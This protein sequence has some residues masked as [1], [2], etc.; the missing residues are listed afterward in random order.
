MTNSPSTAAALKQWLTEEIAESCALEVSEVDPSRPIREYGL[1]SRDALRLVGD[2]EDMLDR[3]L[4]TALIWQH[5][6]IDALVEVLLGEPGETEAA[7]VVVAGATS[8]NGPGTAEPIAV[9]GIGCRLPGGIN[10][11]E[12]FWRLLVEGNHA[13]TR[14][15]D[16][17]WEQ[18]GHDSPEQAE[19][20]SNTTR[21]GGFL[22]QIDLFDA[23]FF[24]IAP[25]EAAAMDPQQRLLLEVAWEA[26]E[27]AGVSAD[28]LRGSQTGVFVG[29]SGNEYSHLTLGDV[30]HIDAWSGTGAAL[31]I[32]ANRLSYVFDL[33]GPSIAVD[34]ACSSS[35]VAVHQAIQSLRAGESEVALAGGANLLLGAGVT[36]TFDQM[37]I[38][39]PDGLCKAFDASADGIARAEGAG[40]VVLKPLS[41]AV[42]D[43]DRVLAVLRGSAVNSD[44]RSNGLTAPN[45]EAQ[46]ALLRTAY[47]SAGVDPAEVDYVEAHGTGTLLGDPIEASALGAVL[48]KG[49][50]NS[51]P[52]LLGSVK[53][54]LGHLEA[55]AGVIG[56]IKTVLALANRRIPA[57]LHFTE[58]NPHIPFDELRITVAAEQQPWPNR[59]RPGRAGVSGFG[60]G[61]TN[62]HVIVEQAPVV[63]Q[64]PTPLA[65]PGQFLLG[66]TSVA[67]LRRTA[68]QLADWLA[69]PGEHVE[70]SDVEHTLARRGSGRS[71]A[72]ITAGTRAELLTGLDALA[73]GTAAPGVALGKRDQI[74]PGPVWVFSGHG[75]QWAGMGKRL[76]TE[77]PVFA[78]AI[79]EIDDALSAVSGPA[80]RKALESGRDL[81]LFDE[82]QPVLFGLQVA[83]ARLWQH[84]GVQPAAVIG[85]SIGEVAAAV[86]AGA[87]S[88]QHGALIAVRRSAR[89]ATTGG[90]GAMAVLELPAT[91]VTRLLAEHP[92]IGADIDVAVYNSPS[93]TVVAGP[94]DKVPAL[95][96]LVEQRGLLARLIKIDVASHSRV[97]DQVTDGLRSD[98]RA[99][100]ALEPSVRI[101][102]TAVDDPRAEVT[103]D[104]AY[105]VGNIRKPVRFTDAVAAAVADG[106]TTFVEISPHPVLFH[107]ISETAGKATVLGTLRRSDSETWHFHANLGSLLAVR[108]MPPA[109]DGRLL[110]VPTTPWTRTVH[111]AKPIIRAVPAGTHPLLGV[112][113][114]LPGE[115]THLWRA[116]LGT[117]AQP[118][119]ADHRIDGRAILAGAC[120]I[121]MAL[122]A[123][124]TALGTTPDRFA[125]KDVALHQPLPLTEHTPVTTTFTPFEDGT[126]PGGQVAVYTKDAEGTWILHC[127]VTVVAADDSAPQAWELDDEHGTGFAPAELYQ[128]LRSL[129]VEYGPAFTGISDVRTSPTG[130]VVTIEIPES[131]PRA[132]YFVHPVLLDNC[133][134]GFAA[135]LSGTNGDDSLY[136]PMEFGSVRLHGD[137]AQGAFAH[138]SITPPE[139]GAAGLVGRLRLL[140]L[141]DRVVLEITDIFVR[142][143][144]RAEI[145]A[146]LRDRLLHRTWQ[147]Q[148]APGTRQHGPVLLVADRRNA[149]V[150]RALATLTAVGLPARV[151]SEVDASV[152]AVEEPESVVLLVDEDGGDGLEAAQRTLLAAAE[153]A[154]TLV[155]RPGEPPRLW[156]VTTS[157]AAVLA[158]D[159]GQ[160]GPAAVR[161]LVRVLAFEHPALRT[162]WLDLDGADPA[163]AAAELSIELTTG[164]ADDE[165]AWRA[166]RRYVGK[167]AAAPAPQSGDLPLVR[168]DGGYVVTGGLGGLG[169]LLA[170]WLADHGAHTLVLNGRSAPKPASA[171]VIEELRAGG[172]RIEVVLGDIAEPGV[173]DRLVAAAGNV[174]G[175]VHAAALFDDRTVEL[176][177]E[178]TVRKTWRPKAVGA[179]RLHEATAELDLDWW[180][181]FSSATALHG[182][183]GQPA[184]STANA[185]LDNLAAYRRAK[186]LP[187][188]TVQWGTWAE[189]GAA[190]DIEVPWL[191]PIAPAEGLG[192]IADLL[193]AQAATVGA[194]R[195][196]APRL[197]AAFPDL[198]KLP[199]FADVLAGHAVAAVESSDW[200]GIAAVRELEPAEIRRLT[201][202]QLRFRVASVMGLQ[203]DALVDDLPLTSLG[204]DSLLAV[205]IRNAFQHDFELN[206][207]VSVMLRGATVADLASRIH[208]ELD[209]SDSSSGA[210]LPRRT[211][212]VPPRD[213]AE[214]LVAAA[215]Q[216]VLGV[217]VGVTHDFA[218]LGGDEAKADAVTALLAERSGHE[219]TTAALFTQP[220]IE[221]IAGKIRELDHRSGPLRVLREGG[222]QTPLFFFHPGGGDTAVFRQLVD[223]IDPDIPAYGFDR[224]DGTTTVEQRITQ[225]LPQLRRIQ[226]Q[227]P[228]R[229]V[230]WSFGG[231]LAYEAAQQL[232]AAGEQVE[233]L[234][235]VDPILPL[236]LETELSEVEL[237][238]R[239][240]ERF[241]EFLETAYGKRVELPFAELARLDDVAQADLLVSTILAAGVV[242]ARVSD[243]ILTH[244][245]RSFLDARMLERYQPSEYT[246]P[247]IF[248]SAASPVPGGL[249]DERFDR[250][251]PARGF[252]AVCTDL[253]LVVVPG[254]HLSVL[255]PPNVNVI[256]EHL[257]AALSRVRQ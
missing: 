88:L 40:I 2:L 224:V 124:S 165:I 143:I 181:G 74:G 36:A 159:P 148:D 85:H 39:A 13:I 171:A 170:G 141:N 15:P 173:A 73:Q 168:P 202:E 31:S 16:G 217:P 104:T 200:P 149:L 180:L 116:D 138:V 131:A 1:T 253:E 245:R 150:D 244:Q 84:Y 25:R 98:L 47:A 130:A 70:L 184:Y 50:P 195:L 54:N 10:G 144:P 128:R 153:W 220:T 156:L 147:P 109:T 182:L 126:R 246:G 203:T 163:R 186:G 190:A 122:T 176:L 118:W 234:G 114:E 78:A 111:W 38:T 93:E 211:V 205:R 26:L 35:L 174:R 100:R 44:G 254:H 199:F 92:E 55:A 222:R 208:A 71:R 30:S 242:D 17:R 223:L 209:V 241:G 134:Q 14:V 9:I 65:K 206:L 162:T 137:P 250:T 86:V 257:A 105:W 256:A 53:T 3:E 135:A 11:P 102:P 252:D 96:D 66:A 187:A 21:W 68:K 113:V 139:P 229:L 230:G 106:F 115:R 219:L 129:G 117:G 175:I 247:A 232:T 52:L 108:A 146:P 121:D 239:R 251:D 215:W 177:D 112:H 32:A 29:I 227:G 132:G 107:A 155:D 76:L 188:T 18:F 198:P 196:N 6:T 97:V 19:R 79:D 91:E 51:A 233:L 59:D 24:G 5:P 46:Q 67:R 49:R 172:T 194:V 167:L 197:V 255:D 236:P 142:R 110:D 12:Q 235:L 192:L 33:R 201:A 231:F 42:R 145:A 158:D 185:Y 34:T 8:G 103:H 83:L 64:Q 161:G 82:V 226:P 61:G 228:Y 212:L 101:Y 221:L 214:R 152:L 23:E 20:L 125:L 63:D 37:G 127:G 157:A 140:D 58:P 183:P 136:M 238:E 27:H 243:A 22:D 207:P 166:G 216:E 119:L 72:V 43:G 164:A 210:P 225:L 75:A 57:S 90:T 94:H 218:S 179:W 56:L 249:R 191:H 123:A 160:P 154:R 204:V 48:G 193:T 69:G 178:D 213:A 81:A 99:V 237:L 7:P 95:V 151:V 89:L 120:Y 189:V 62:A 77:E 248:Y 133:L 45:P 169:L 87:I 41:A 80:L 60:F 240:F 28:S 4:P